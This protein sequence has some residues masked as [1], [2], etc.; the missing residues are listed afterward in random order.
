MKRT[1]ILWSCLCLAASALA[2]GTLYF[3]N[4]IL[5]GGLDAPVL[6]GGLEGPKL[7]NATSGHWW[8]AVLYAAAPGGTLAPV[9][10]PIPFRSGS[11]AGYWPGETRTI[12]GVPE[13]GIA[14]L[15]VRVF[16]QLMAPTFEDVAAR[17]VGD[18]GVSAILPRV[19]TGGASDPAPMAG[20]QSFFVLAYVPEPSTTVLV[21][22]GTV[23]LSRGFTR[24]GPAA[25]RCG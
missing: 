25:G 14:Q 11:N 18:F 12:P 15:Q 10:D 8:V 16:C 21:L 17:A 9:G 22:L 1:F 20:L 4:R 2:Q 24:R 23:V 5:G 7:D 13:G 6:W 19:T 3:G